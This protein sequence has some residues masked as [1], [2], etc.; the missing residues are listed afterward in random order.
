MKLLRNAKTLEYFAHGS[1]TSDQ[2]LAQ[3]FPDIRSAT[4]ACIRH[5]LQDVELVTQPDDFE[6]SVLDDARLPVSKQ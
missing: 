4:A 6:T 3:T 2:T 1:W 5:R